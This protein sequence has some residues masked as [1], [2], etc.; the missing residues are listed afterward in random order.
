[1]RD[2][3]L[4]HACD[5]HAYVLMTNHVHLLAT[6]RTVGAV[7]RM[8]QMLGRCYVGCFNARYRRSGTLWEG[9]TIPAWSIRKTICC[10]AIATSNS[11]PS[12][13]AWL[14]YQRTIAGT[15]ATAFKQEAHKLI[16]EL[17]ETATWDDLA[18]RIETI[19]DIE[20]GLADSA[21]DRVTENSQ[22][23]R[24]FGLR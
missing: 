20:A 14:R 7:S 18:E 23:R 1:V 19:I 8:M 4:R 21:A 10:V 12:G 24:E 6:P 11:T 9:A 16:D 5:V 2:A 17:P 13:R 3:A 22:V 15:M